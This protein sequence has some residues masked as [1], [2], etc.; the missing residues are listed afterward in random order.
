MSSDQKKAYNRYLVLYN[1]YLSDDVTPD[2]R[3]QLKAEMIEIERS[4]GIQGDWI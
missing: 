3:E 2:Q 1:T 4:L